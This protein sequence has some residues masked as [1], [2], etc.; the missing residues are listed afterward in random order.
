[1]ALFDLIC[2]PKASS[3]PLLPPHHEPDLLLLLRHQAVEVPLK[4]AQ[5]AAVM[6]V[7]HSALGVVRSPVMITGARACVRASV[8]VYMPCMF[9]RASVSLCGSPRSHARAPTLHR[10]AARRHAGG[11]E[12][13]GAV[14]HHQPGAQDCCCL[15]APHGHPR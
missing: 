6:E 9:I 15:P 7:V 8:R 11:V 1:M 12:A 13:V 4:I 2:A 3:L 5:T 14:G 10:R